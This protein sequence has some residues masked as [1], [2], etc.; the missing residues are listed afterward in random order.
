[1]Q[2][3][4]NF[5]LFGAT[6]RMGVEVRSLLSEH[7]VA[8]YCG[9]TSGQGEEGDGKEADI[10]IDFSVPAALSSN[11]KIAQRYRK[12]VMIGTTG[13]SS[14]QEEL[15]QK[16]A[17]EIPVLRASNTSFG[18]AVM[19]K[20]AQAAAQLLDESYDIEIIEAHHR[21]KL[22]APSGTA[23]SLGQAVAQGRGTTL[24][25]AIAYPDRS[26]RRF[27]GTIGFS[28]Q[29]GGGIIGEHQIHFMGDDEIISLSHQGL[30][31]RLFARGAIKAGLWLKG[32]PPGL[33]TMQDALALA[34]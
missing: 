32:Q 24:A 2:T 28:V 14:A 16:S 21:H 15:I 9:G 13:L 31:R 22:D 20:L 12:P 17:Q 26:G 23:L 4:T 10:F 11:L 1:M 3:K 7:P 29:R 34:A 25:A 27:P 6:G 19:T 5:Y 30:S 33:Y 18:V 8:T